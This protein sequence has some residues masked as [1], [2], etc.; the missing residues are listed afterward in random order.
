[1]GKQKDIFAV[2]ES[3]DTLEICFSS[4]LASIDR[5]C[6]IVTRFLTADPAGGPDL[7]AIHLLLREGLT[8]AIRHGNKND[9][10]KRVMFQSKRNRGKSICFEIC[11]Q[12]EGFDWKA[13]PISNLPENQDHGRG[14]LIIKTY[15]THYSY[16]ECGNCLYLE[17]TISHKI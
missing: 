11:D 13:Q 7:F 6:R 15:A 8:N 16:N 10:E 9:P 17:K 1:V 5:V 12:G 14:I 4:C 2:I 3:K